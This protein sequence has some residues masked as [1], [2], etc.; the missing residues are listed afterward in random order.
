[1]TSTLDDSEWAGALSSRSEPFARPTSG[2]I[3]TKMIT[4]DGGEMTVVRDVGG[5]A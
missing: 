3:A 5:V 1:M 2:L 4:A